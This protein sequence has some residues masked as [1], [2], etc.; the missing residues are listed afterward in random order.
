MR[1]H[2]LP[3][4]WIAP[5]EVREPREVVRYWATRPECGARPTCLHR[6]GTAILL[7]R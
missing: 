5:P 1:L 3:E 4:A 7:G 2:K 6:Q